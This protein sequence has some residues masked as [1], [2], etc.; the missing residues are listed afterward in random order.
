MAFDKIKF[1]M[2]VVVYAFGGMIILI[3]AIIIWVL[4]D[5]NNDDDNIGGGRGGAN[6]TNTAGF[7]AF[8]SGT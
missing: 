5:S 3:I 2:Q 1:N 8:F 4:S 7:G 6:F